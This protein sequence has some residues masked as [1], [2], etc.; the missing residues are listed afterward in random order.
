MENALLAIAA[1]AAPNLIGKCLGALHTKAMG[2]ALPTPRQSAD[3]V[4]RD[5]PSI[6][7]FYLKEKSA[8]SS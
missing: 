4:K 6:F 3:C 7:I 2:A 5:L 1:E 8:Y